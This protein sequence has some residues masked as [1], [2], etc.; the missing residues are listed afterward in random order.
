MGNTN[1]NIWDEPSGIEYIV[2]NENKNE[3]KAATL[4]KLVQELTSEETYGN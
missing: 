4:N 2:L 1:M 3:I